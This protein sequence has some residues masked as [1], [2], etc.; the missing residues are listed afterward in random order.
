MARFYYMKTNHRFAP[1]D[2][3]PCC[4]LTPYEERFLVLY[5]LVLCGH[6]MHGNS[7]VPQ[8]IFHTSKLPPSGCVFLILRKIILYGIFDATIRGNRTYLFPISSTWNKINPDVNRVWC[9][10]EIKS[11]AWKI[12]PHICMMGCVLESHLE[13]WYFQE[14]KKLSLRKKQGFRGYSREFIL[15]SQ[16]QEQ[17]NT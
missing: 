16:T 5:T 13:N 10:S 7:V 2:S 15:T 11:S 1:W 4:F 9:S 17:H 3:L 14:C 12:A 8:D 6:Q